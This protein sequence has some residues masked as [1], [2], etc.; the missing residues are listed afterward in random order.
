[1]TLLSSFAPGGVF[2]HNDGAGSILSDAPLIIWLY[3]VLEI[4]VLEGIA[5]RCHN[6]D[7]LFCIT[8]EIPHPTSVPL[9]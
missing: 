9:P 7:L 1:M 8:V 3:L 6:R 4:L 2:I 5:R